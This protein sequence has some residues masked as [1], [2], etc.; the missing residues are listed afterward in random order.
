MALCACP[1]G[2][3]PA[4]V[5]SRCLCGLGSVFQTIRIRLSLNAEFS[6]DRLLSLGRREARLLHVKCASPRAHGSVVSVRSALPGGLPDPPFQS[7]T[8]A[9]S[10]CWAA[11]QALRSRE[12]GG[13]E[14]GAALP[15]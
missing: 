9:A 7:E 13:Q 12:G 5:G 11:L 14:V 3:R 6:S 1:R 10:G 8:R 2:P 4:R 15:Q